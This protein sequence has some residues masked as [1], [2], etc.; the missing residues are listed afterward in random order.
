MKSIVIPPE[1]DSLQKFEF[2]QLRDSVR[3]M[4][5]R[6]SQSDLAKRLS[7]EQVEVIYSV[8]H[9]FFV[10]GKFENA[11]NVFKML[12]LYR[13]FDARN[14]EAYATTLKRLGRFEEA[15]PIYAAALFF[16]DLS[17]PMPSVHIAECLAAIGRAD[18]SM[19]MLRPI[20]ELANLD[21]AYGEVRS[22]C[23]GLQAMLRKGE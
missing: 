3:E 19:N 23:E 7:N 15:I 14:M 4:S 21:A 2:L 10:Q 16:G 8:G 11:L 22:R 1:P 9:A 5:L 17:D 20:L 13:P 18:D 6:F 12:M